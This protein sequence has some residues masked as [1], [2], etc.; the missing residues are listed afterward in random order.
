MKGEH[1]EEPRQAPPRVTD[2]EGT[3]QTIEARTVHENPRECRRGWRDKTDR[4][5]CTAATL[6]PRQGND[7]REPL[8][9]SIHRHRH[10]T[11]S[12]IVQ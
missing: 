2:T 6:H 10:R 3:G 5:R 11:V 1:A 8:P 12:G 9:C 7:E 4:S